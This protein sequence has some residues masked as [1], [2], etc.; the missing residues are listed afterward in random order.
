MYVIVRRNRKFSGNYGNFKKFM[1][2]MD[3]VVKFATQN[4][5]GQP[6]GSNF[7][8]NELSRDFRPA[9]RQRIPTI[10][11]TDKISKVTHVRASSILPRFGGHIFKSVVS[12]GIVSGVATLPRPVV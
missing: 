6:H 12:S 8:S 10:F 4:V 1:G 7:L 3:G 5:R 11:F 2:R 9:K